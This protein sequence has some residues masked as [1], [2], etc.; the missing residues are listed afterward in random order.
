MPGRAD[1]D[2]RRR[3]LRVAA[4]ASATLVALFGLELVLRLS[5]APS[6]LRDPR[7]D[8]HWIL[9]LAEERERRGPEMGWGNTRLDPLLGWTMRPGR[10]RDGESTNSEGMRGGREYE[11]EKPPDRRRIAAFGDSFT[12]GL[13]VSDEETWSARLEEQLPS[14]EVL[15]FAVNG[16]GI[17]QQYLRWTRDGIPFAPDVAVLGYYVPDFH[18]AALSVREFPKPRFVPVAD[19]IELTNVPVPHPRL[20]LR[21]RLAGCRSALRLAD[22]A[23]F[24]LRR[25]RPGDDEDTLGEKELL[26]HGILR[27]FASSTAEEGAQLFVVL[28]PHQEFRAYPDHLRIE[29]AV[30][31]SC[32]EL[33]VPVLNLTEPLRS[34][35]LEHPEQPLY[36][37]VH[38][39][40]TPRGHAEAARR[41]ADFLLAHGAV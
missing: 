18:R 16:H 7:R 30:V 12:L 20:L 2:H 14:A 24:A 34:W 13:G 23:G 1:P 27:R 35:Q 33:G 31:R 36:S 28:I 15:N 4:A 25:L 11:R 41:I 6:R 32:G 22:L 17:D 3:K 29:R 38:G 26:S 9:R 5:F 8:C 21:E 19:R 10:S 40:W 37:D 39:H